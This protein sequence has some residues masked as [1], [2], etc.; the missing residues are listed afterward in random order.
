MTRFNARI[1]NRVA[2]R[3]GK[4][5]EKPRSCT[6]SVT[7]AEPILALKRLIENKGFEVHRSQSCQLWRDMLRAPWPPK[8]KL[9]ALAPHVAPWANAKAGSFG[10]G[11]VQSFRTPLLPDRI[12]WLSGL[13]A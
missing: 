12:R 1:H 7:A 4:T 8:P 13:N 2:K 9:A 11:P 3:P 10:Y 5:W 6:V